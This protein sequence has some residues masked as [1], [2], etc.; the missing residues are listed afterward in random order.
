MTPMLAFS[1]RT[2]IFLTMQSKVTGSVAAELAVENAMAKASDAPL[3]KLTGPDP[4]APAQ[5]N[6]IVARL[7]GAGP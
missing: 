1:S 2:P 4:G 5:R 3:Q 7:D 6:E